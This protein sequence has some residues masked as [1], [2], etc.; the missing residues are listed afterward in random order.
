[1]KNFINK[2]CIKNTKIT[3]ILKHNFFY[4]DNKIEME[5]GCKNKLKALSFMVQK[6]TLNWSK[7]CTD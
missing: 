5:A 7:L 1:M 3:I 2:F 4:K 6:E